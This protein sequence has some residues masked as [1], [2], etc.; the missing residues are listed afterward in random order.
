MDTE[1]LLGISI[2]VFV[3][4]LI[5]F[6]IINKTVAALFGAVLIGAAAKYYKFADLNNIMAFIDY[7]TIMLLMSM[8]IIVGILGKTGFFQV[9]AYKT[10]K[11]S[12]GNPLKILVNLTILTAVLSGFLDNVTTI[13][14]I[15]PVTLAVTQALE[16]NARPY[17]I[18]E[19][20]ASN[21]GGAGTLVGDPPNIMIGNYAHL[22][23]NDFVINLMPIIIVNLFVEIGIIYLL[24]HSMFQNLKYN[25]NVE[26]DEKK[27]IIKDQALFKKSIIVLIATVIMFIVGEFFGIPAAVSA[28]AGAIVLLIISGE[29]ITRALNYVEWPTLLF[30]AGLFVVVGGVEKMGVLDVI[31]SATLSHIGE[32][33]TGALTM[34]TWMAAVLSSVVDNIP[35]TAMLI[36]LMPYFASSTG[37]QTSV[38]FWALSLG[39]CLGGNATA[40]GASANVV[41]ISIAQKHG[42]PINFK[43]Y[44]K[45]GMIITFVTIA[46]AN[47]YVLARYIWL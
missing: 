14:L 16:V 4:V 18:S 29:N 9:I 20:F 6:D 19:I 44:L 33:S 30:F 17:I 38:F 5:M 8:M 39:A 43:S 23:F 2:L 13:L 12:K 37:T 1:T 47:I 7:E 46:L 27:Y 45:D 41:G 34:I 21:I 22:G 32:S 24:Y 15:L 36:P 28:F 40:I 10:V 26:L 11:L 42:V 3:Y 35:I 31:A 25:Q